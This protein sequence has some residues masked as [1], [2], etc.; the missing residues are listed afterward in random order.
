MNARKLTIL[1]LIAFLGLSLTSCGTARRAGKDAAVTLLS[2]GII[3]YGGGVD[4]FTSAQEVREG[5]GG[6]V[7]TE[8]LTLPPAFAIHAV[9]HTFIV[10]A[11]AVDFVLSPVYGVAE[12]H[13]Y[14]PEVEPLDYYTGTI[15]DKEE[16]GASGT[17]AQSGEPGTPPR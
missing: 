15:F 11:H 10:A 14:G 16:G 3:L 4:G 9:K 12:L 8:V 7:F 17:D 5:L 6:G 2:P 13:P 1:T